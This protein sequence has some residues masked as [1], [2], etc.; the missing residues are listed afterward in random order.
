MAAS[1]LSLGAARMAACSSSEQRP[2]S[3]T[4]RSSQPHS[5]VSCST[6]T[7]QYSLTP[8]FPLQLPSLFSHPTFASPSL[9]LPSPT[10]LPPPH[11]TLASPSLPPSLPPLFTYFPLSLLPLLSPH[12]P[13]LFP[14][15]PSLPTSS[16]PPP[17]PRRGQSGRS[18]MCLDEAILQAVCVFTEKAQGGTKLYIF[19]EK[20]ES[21]TGA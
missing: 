14:H 18:G 12:P 3:H 4:G 5:L 17:S 2:L 9:L 11:P 19:T 1:P 16:L 6:C 13:T 7:V 10:S 15:P 8:P 20:P 21:T